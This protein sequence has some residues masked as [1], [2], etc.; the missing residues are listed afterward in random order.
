[1]P[2][3]YIGLPWGMDRVDR[4]PV[5]KVHRVEV[6][7]DGKDEDEANPVMPPGQFLTGDHNLVNLRV[8]LDYR[9]I[10]EDEELENY[11]LQADRV[12]G[13]VARAAE[14]VLAEW[15][16]GRTVDDILLEGKS[17]LPGWLVER[18][19]RRIGP[20]RLGVRIQA[21]SVTHLA[22]PRQVKEA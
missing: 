4:V 14:S 6:G 11:V 12:E 15:A 9:V 8:A 7:W 16:A 20:Y 17:T 13:L 21:A 3:L 10:E 5:G 1:E 19:Q 18:V 22:P 2:G